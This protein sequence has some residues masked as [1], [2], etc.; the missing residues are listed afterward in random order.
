MAI[1]FKEELTDG[2]AVF[3][4]RL[5]PVSTSR[6]IWLA[7]A[8]VLLCSGGWWKSAVF[9]FL[10]LL[11]NAKQ[12]LEEKVV[13]TKGL[14]LQLTSRSAWVTP[15]GSP[16][17]A[18]SSSD[19]IETADIEEIIIAEAVTYWDVFYYLAVELHGCDRTKVPFRQLCPREVSQLIRVL[20]VLRQMLEDTPYVE[21]ADDMPRPKRN[22]RSNMWRRKAMKRP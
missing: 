12:V 21:D 17:W 4:A 18:S 16:V 22:A 9:L 15:W 2:W 14:G 1:S 7:A 3:V 5:E 19:F 10:L 20:Q 8:L 6:G 13:C 11:L